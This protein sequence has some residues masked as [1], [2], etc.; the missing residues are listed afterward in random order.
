MKITKRKFTYIFFQ[1]VFL[2]ITYALFNYSKI[3][4]SKSSFINISRY[5]LF[6]ILILVILNYIYYKKKFNAYIIIFFTFCLFQFGTP[7]LYALNNEY[8]N[9]YI[10]FQNIK[11]LIESAKY[12]IICIQTFNLGSSIMVDRNRSLNFVESYKM[13]NCKEV[14]VFVAKYLFIIMGVIVLPFVLRLVMLSFQYGYNY[15]KNDTMGIYNPVIKLAKSMF[16][17]SGFLWLVYCDNKRVEKIILVLLILYSVFSMLTGGRTEGLG[18]FLVILYFMNY[19]RE[20]KK[21]KLIKNVVFLLGSVLILYL[22]T[23]IVQFRTNNV[24]QLTIYKAIE[25]TI[26]EMGFNFTSICF[27]KKYIPE[28]MSFQNGLSYINSIICLI[29]KSLD[30][31]GIIENIYN[32]LPELWLAKSLIHSYSKLYEFG[33]GYSIIAESFYNFGNYGWIAIMFIGMFVQ[34]LIGGDYSK[35]PKFEKYIQLVMLW[36]LITF[37]RRSFYDLIKSFEYNIIFII[38]IIS[39]VYRYYISKTRYKIIN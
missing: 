34:I 15:I 36:S 25:K 9:F 23:Y 16:V 17:P 32:N 22:L 1:I 12:S 30:P 29:P 39:L 33:V 35:L 10:E 2:F 5:G 26:E 18:I 11:I 7:V 4:I 3:E 38:L 31:T 13:F 24:E 27:T 8:S 20:D 28:L 37:P 6:I 19:N 21:S 14:I